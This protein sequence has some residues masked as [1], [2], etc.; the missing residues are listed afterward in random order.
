MT[1]KD[2]GTKKENKIVIKNSGGL[3]KEEIEKMKQDADQH[4]ADDKKRRELVEVRN[5]ADQLAHSIEK[6]LREHAEKLSADVK[7]QIE[8]TVKKLKETKDGDDLAAIKAAMEAVQTA[9]YKM[10]EE[11]YKNVPKPEAGSAAGPEKPTGSTG[12]DS[13]DAEYEVKK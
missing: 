7:T 6:Q 13:V 2:L 11:I 1:A 5:Q 4:A 10:G 3:S 12:G 8:E 9:A